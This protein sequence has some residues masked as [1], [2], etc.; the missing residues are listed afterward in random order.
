MDWVANVVQELTFN[1]VG[2]KSLTNT[3]TTGTEAARF[4]V[5]LHADQVLFTVK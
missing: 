4:T 5:Q 1:R 3:T 2:I